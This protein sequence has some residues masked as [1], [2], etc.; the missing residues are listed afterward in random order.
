ML[1]TITLS[2]VIATAVLGVR[3]QVTIGAAEMPHAGDELFRT[4]ATLNPFINYWS[5]GPDHTWNFG[6][7]A[8][9]SQDGT[10]YQTVGSTNLVYQLAYADIFFNP[11]RANHATSGV[12]IPFNELLPIEEPYTF[13]YRSNNVYKKVG[14]GAE[15]SGIPVPIIFENHDVIYPLPL[16]YGMDGHSSYSSYNIDVPTLAYYGYQQ[17][18]HLWVD[19]WGHITTPAGGFEALR[20]VTRVEARDSIQVDQLS[21]GF[22]IDRPTVHEYKWLA[23]GI[24]VP[25]L[26][27]NTV[28][29]LGIEMVTE[30]HFY[31]A[32]RSL[33]VAEPLAATLC[34]GDQV[35]VP[36][37]ATGVF[38]PGGFLQNAN[39]FR[40]QLSNANGDFS[41]PVNIG[42]VTSTGSGTIT[43]TIPMNTLA[44]NGYRIRVIA[45]NPSFTGTDNGMDIVIGAPPMAQIV[46][47]GL[48]FCEGGS[49]MLE[50]MEVPGATYQWMQDGEDMTGADGS[51]LMVT[52]PG[53]YSVR[54]TNSCGEQTSAAVTVEMNEAPAHE[55]AEDMLVSCNGA[56]VM[57]TAVNTT[58]LT[59]LAYTWYMDGSMI[60][61][62]ESAVLETAASG[63]YH[64]VVTEVNSGCTHAT[65]TISVIADNAVVAN[66]EAL[67]ATTF[68]NGGS[69]DLLATGAEGADHDW[70]LDGLP[71]DGADAATY[72]ASASG[73]YTVITTSEWG[74]ISAHSEAVEV[75][76]NM[77]PEAALV[78][79]N[80]P[81]VF[82]EGG[83]VT[84]SAQ[85]NDGLTYTWSL[86]GV[87]LEGEVNAELTATLSG[88]YAVVVAN[89]ECAA[90]V[91]NSIEVNVYEV[92][93][94]PAITVDGNT[95]FCEGGQVL[96]SIDA[97]GMMVQWIMDG[98]PIADAEAETFI[99]T[100]SGTYSVI[101]ESMGGCLAEAADPV[102]VEVTPMPA[103][104]AITLQDDMLVTDA[105]GDIQ[106]F[107][108]GEPIDGANEASLL[109]A[110]NGLYTV[111]T[112]VNGC[113][114]ISEPYPLINVGIHEI[115]GMDVRVY[116]NPTQGSVMVELAEVR[117]G[118][119]YRMTD[120]AGRLVLQGAV[121]GNRMQLDLQEQMPGMYMLMI[122]DDM[123]G[124]VLRII[125]N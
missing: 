88:T 4:R 10:E 121:L 85:A 30:I 65:G 35:E 76:V 90:A 11:N 3:A 94:M 8:A 38:N 26:Q 123:S 101:V 62:E 89:G 1:R 33:Q 118:M 83:S 100:A 77:V 81:V 73:A 25:V 106:W 9:A 104:P 117:P 43:A 113:E 18:R 92:P 115:T 109:P 2:I 93:E 107:L 91:S 108:N 54:V 52:E 48:A 103:T 14:Y 84:L 97:E 110:Q 22:G 32:E 45:T 80:G 37:A 112:S 20:V 116:P 31:D 67:S 27:I 82:C 55:I 50:A 7:L 68:C 105:V 58:D 56:Q 12:D 44:G 60:D 87:V 70:Y 61:G 34:P 29:L 49:V 64:L 39:V 63:E 53:D 114:S 74:C 79:A 69:V 36:Y 23:P 6:D 119:H 124:Q 47:N 99:A 16:T 57:I 21:L 59:A 28:T 13:Y 71:I 24:R 51:G 86:D 96:L 66:V 120:A 102:V 98:G 41:N 95:M 17:V 72:T 5:S 46:S 19:G 40:A 42:Q 75:V 122:S 125:R 111:I 78:E 15:V